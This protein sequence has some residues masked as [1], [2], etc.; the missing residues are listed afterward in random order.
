MRQKFKFLSIAISFC[1]VLVTITNAQSRRDELESQISSHS[2]EIKKLEEEIKTIQG[3]LTNTTKQATTLKG[4]VDRLEAISKKLS[5]DIK[6]TESKISQTELEIEKLELDIGRKEGDISDFRDSLSE[7]MRALKEVSD[8]SLVEMVLSERRLSDF[9]VEKERLVQVEAEVYQTIG[10][11]KIAQQVLKSD[12]DVAQAEKQKL[13]SLRSKLA[14][15]KKINDGNKS[16]QADL[17]KQTKNQEA[18]YRSLLADKQAKKDAFA[19]ELAA[20][21]AQLKLDVDLSKLPGGG[22]LSWPL[23]DVYITQEFGRTADAKRLYVS[24]THNGI[25]LRAAVGTPIKSAADGTVLG[26]G[27]TDAVC[28][29]ASY[30]KWVLVKHSNGLTTLYAHLSL[31]KVGQ[32]QA[33][34]RG[35]LLGYSGQTGYATG[36]HLHFTV[37]ASDGVQIQQKK[38]AVCQGTYTLPL[39]DLKA[40]L[41]PMLYLK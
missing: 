1:L 21:E 14:D 26:I 32:G 38:S 8:H 28:R 15:Q 9:W 29:D 40:Y 19:R 41:D 35:S 31:I 25:D 17:L 13:S 7:S 36:P 18:N 4:E 39:A 22:V 11:L 12:R 6:L 37:Y 34:T 23:D 30:G 10:E 27:D 24:G 33:V 20:F 16:E 2:Q 5:A 3:S